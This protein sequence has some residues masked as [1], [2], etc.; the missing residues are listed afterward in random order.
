MS[1]DEE[2]KETL[3]GLI[4]TSVPIEAGT[5]DIGTMFAGFESPDS[6]SDDETN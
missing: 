3:M 6:N 1:E 5:E 2:L 4:L